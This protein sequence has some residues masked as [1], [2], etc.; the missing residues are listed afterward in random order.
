[1]NAL[2]RVSVSDEQPLFPGH[3]RHR[4]AGVKTNQ[5]EGKAAE[6]SSVKDRRVDEKATTGAPQPRQVG[7]EKQRQKPYSLPVGATQYARYGKNPEPAESQCVRP[8]LDNSNGGVDTKES[9]ETGVGLRHK[10]SS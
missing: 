9:K 5:H 4:V 7:Q 3:V 1:M 2:R 6:T 8:A 10:R